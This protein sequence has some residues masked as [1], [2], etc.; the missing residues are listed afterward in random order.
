[1]TVAMAAQLGLLG[2]MKQDPNKVPVENR[3]FAELGNNGGYGGGYG[4]EGMQGPGGYGT[5][6]GG[7]GPQ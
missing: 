7:Y 6:D 2:E 5:G 4:G 1:M 3:S